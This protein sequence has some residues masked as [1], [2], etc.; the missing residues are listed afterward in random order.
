MVFTIF[1]FG[2]VCWLGL[3]LINRDLHSPRLR[4]A[5]LGLVTYALA[6]GCTVLS[7]YAPTPALGLMLTRWSW[8]F[9]ALS[10]PFWAGAILFLLPEEVA[11]RASFVRIWSYAALPIVA[12]CFLLSV[13][14]PSLFHGTPTTLHPGALYFTFNAFALLSLLAVVCLGWQAL[15]SFQP[16][17]AGILVLPSLLFL[18]LS[19]F[20][21]LFPQVWPLH[22]W[23]LFLVGIDLLVLGGAIV[24][25][26][27]CDQGEALLPDLFRSFDFSFGTVLLFA[28]QVL[29]IILLGTG[30]TFP[31]LVLFLTTIATA[32]AIQTFSHQV[33]T[34]LD[35][36]ALAHFPHMR[37]T[38]AE[39]REVADTLPRVSQT[40][41]LEAIDEV[42][43][44][45]LTRRAFSHFGDISRLAASPLTHLPQIA[46]R[47]AGR[48]AG[49]DTLGRATELKALLTECIQRLKPQQQ[50]DFG[51]SDE[52]RYYNA[53]Y[54]P[55]V[56]GLKPYSNR[57]HQIPADPVARKALEWFH[58]YVPERTLHN[59][60][61]AAT[62]LIAQDLRE[63]RNF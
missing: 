49:D 11:F 14:T 58:L 60:Q 47:L 37:E 56:V 35:K 48:G 5:G 10:T 23:I 9:F 40:L 55:Y 28:G 54:F 6:W 1:I 7:S 52:W 62:K 3:Y 4:Y 19:L 63:M 33:G 18:A 12:F 27:A 29:L 8:S 24:V 50:G 51:T 25:L 20:L 41:D 31:L 17:R 57:R 34:L 2:I 42:E 46:I 53:L 16:K 59:W 44:E 43:F 26:D 32:I 61:T 38:R 30:L 45:R 13:S 36:V 15:R 21:L 22:T 39:L